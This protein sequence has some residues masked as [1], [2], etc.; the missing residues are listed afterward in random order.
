MTNGRQASTV[1]R[2]VIVAAI[3]LVVAAVLLVALR[4]GPESPAEDGG[5]DTDPVA[6]TTPP[7]VVPAP[8]PEPVVDAAVTVSPQVVTIGVPGSGAVPWVPIKVIL[9][10]ARA[11]SRDPEAEYVADSVRQAMLRALQGQ[12]SVEI[13]QISAAELAAAVPP[14]AGT[15]REDNVVRLAIL[16]RFDGRLVAEVSEQS[17]PGS[18]SWNVSLLVRRANG[19]SSTTGNLAKSGDLRLGTDVESLGARFAQ[20]IVQRATEAGP[21]SAA[22][23]NA[24]AM[25]LDATRSEEDRLRSLGELLNDGVGLSPEEIAAAVDLA[26]RSAS[27]STRRSVWSRLGQGAYDPAL[28]QALS[29]ALLT[30]PD[31]TVR[32]QAA[33]ALATYRGDGSTRATLEHAFR[34]DSSFEV[35][36]ASQMAA[37]D[38]DEQRAFARR[39]L[40]DRSLTPL[41]RLAPTTHSRMGT[42]AI[43]TRPYGTAEAEEA[44]ALAEMMAGTNDPQIELAALG[45]LRMTL[46][47]ARPLNGVPP[48]IDPQVTRVLIDSARLGDENVRVEALNLLAQY[49]SG[50][51]EARA[52][53]ESVLEREPQ[54]ATRLGLAAVLGRQPDGNSP[55]ET[56]AIATPPPGL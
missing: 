19:G 33:R 31:A 11:E 36:L 23:A 43:I 14:N 46:S 26:T 28:A 4:P 51:P 40:L 49:S 9:L 10:P 27:A 24:R 25:L 13:V 15:L 37:M 35:R 48:D 44:L 3:L 55:R 39:R 50:V 45:V 12:T 16:G 41:E 30:D 47:T 18:P 38:A 17:P 54:L 29:Y 6:A 1:R 56:P 5:I 53:L 21:P 20:S 8:T 34:N 42:T 7:Q 32:M 22:S 2:P 52:M